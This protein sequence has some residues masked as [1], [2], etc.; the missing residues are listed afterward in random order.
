MELHSCCACKYINEEMLCKLKSFKLVSEG[1]MLLHLALL[2]ERQFLTLLQLEIVDLNNMIIAERGRNLDLRFKQLNKEDSN[3]LMDILSN[4]NCSDS[5]YTT[6]IAYCQTPSTNS[7]ETVP[8]HLYQTLKDEF[9]EQVLISC[10]NLDTIKK[11]NM[12]DISKLQEQLLEIS[13][14]ATKT[15]NLYFS[16]SKQFFKQKLENM[17][18]HQNFLDNVDNISKRN[19]IHFSEVKHKLHKTVASTAS[20]QTRGVLKALQRQLGD[21]DMMVNNLRKRQQKLEEKL[22][23]LSKNFTLQR[24]QSDNTNE[25]LKMQLKNEKERYKALEERRL[26]E[27]DDL[28][29]DIQQLR[30]DLARIK[31]LENDN[32]SK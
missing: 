19:A 11:D 24:Q 29:T 18:N 12:K 17:Y 10:D 27:L 1:N 32:L 9:K 30:K 28:Q 4:A 16:Y 23:T 22:E 25:Q 6:S 13:K 3:I 21:R 5:L 26:V 14:H 2:K 20:E 15:L 8:I 7:N 31:N